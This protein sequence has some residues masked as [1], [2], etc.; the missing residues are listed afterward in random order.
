VAVKRLR[1]LHHGVYRF[2]QF[3]PIVLGGASEC[4]YSTLMLASRALDDQTRDSRPA[5]L[6][7]QALEQVASENLFI[8]ARGRADYGG[9]D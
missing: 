3:D 7:H 1:S 2:D 4:G 9:L 5:T 6:E 8:A